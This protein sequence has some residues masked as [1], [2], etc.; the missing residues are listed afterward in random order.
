[1]ETGSSLLAPVAHKCSGASMVIYW[2]QSPTSVVVPQ[3]SS[4][5]S[6]RGASMVI[7]WLQSWCLNGH[8]SLGYG[9]DGHWT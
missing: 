8:C 3:W 7:Y 1:M 9:K 5:G 4:T 6:S 2:L